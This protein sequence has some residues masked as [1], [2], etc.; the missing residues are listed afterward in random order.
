MGRFWTFKLWNLEVMNL[1]L[2]VPRSSTASPPTGVQSGFQPS[3]EGLTEFASQRAIAEL[4]SRLD[5]CLLLTDKGNILYASDNLQALMPQ[6]LS[7]AK[8]LEKAPVMSREL[9]LICQTL[10]QARSHFPHQAG[11]STALFSPNKVTLCRCE[12][13]GS[14]LRSASN[15][16]SSC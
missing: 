13:A 4:E 3:R 14:I 15:L 7:P 1:P 5:N 11:K 12:R 9:V 8:A 16:A 6:L 2:T 10:K